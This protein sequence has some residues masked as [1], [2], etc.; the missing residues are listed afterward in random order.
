MRG[1]YH[2]K[3]S[4]FV[5][6]VNLGNLLN[7]IQQFPSEIPSLQIT[8]VIFFTELIFLDELL[9]QCEGILLLYHLG[10]LFLCHTSKLQQGGLAWVA[11]QETKWE[12]CLFPS[13]S[14]PVWPLQFG[15][16][17]QEKIK[18]KFLITYTA[19]QKIFF[20]G[21][22]TIRC[23]KQPSYQISQTMSTALALSFL[24]LK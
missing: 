5:T 1:F 3:E 17:G 23:K 6:A 16:V 8:S 22:S 12:L 15:R 21:T 24:E 4:L 13:E 14:H 11:V 2:R 19:R 20:F 10:Q 7:S 18:S 9:L